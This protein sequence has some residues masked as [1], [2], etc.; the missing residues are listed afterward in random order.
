MN[1]DQ[2]KEVSSYDFVFIGNHSHTHEYRWIFHTMTSK[3]ILKFYK[4]FEKN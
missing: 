2:I 3:E 1:W 4:I